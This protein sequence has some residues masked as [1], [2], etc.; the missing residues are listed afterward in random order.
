MTLVLGDFL[1]FRRL[2][3]YILTCYAKKK[4]IKSTDM[5]AVPATLTAQL[6]HGQIK[7]MLVSECQLL[8]R[9]SSS[10]GHCLPRLSAGTPQGAVQSR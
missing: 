1:W 3:Q 2:V 10:S 6:L 4:M 9:P 8:P 5:L 7:Y